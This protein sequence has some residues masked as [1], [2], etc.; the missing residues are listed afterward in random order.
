MEFYLIGVGDANKEL[1]KEI[2]T[3]ANKE[4][5]PENLIFVKDRQTLDIIMTLV[6]GDKGLLRFYKA[7]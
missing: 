4:V 1:L 7:F 5:K 3:A 6:D 2:A